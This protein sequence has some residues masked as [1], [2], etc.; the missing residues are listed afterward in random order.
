MSKFT[1]SLTL[2]GVFTVCLLCI[3]QLPA[4]AKNI[5]TGTC[6]TGVKWS[7][8]DETLTIKGNGKM[9]DFENPT[10]SVATLPSWNPYKKS[11]KHLAIVR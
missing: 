6:G 4:C 2:K 3:S 1:K 5:A 9:N 7:L 11:I 10:N 8:D